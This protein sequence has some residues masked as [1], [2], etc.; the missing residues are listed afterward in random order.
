MSLQNTY[1]DWV[2][3]ELLPALPQCIAQRN[4]GYWMSAMEV[5]MWKRCTRRSIGNEKC[6]HH[7]Y[8][9]QLSCITDQCSPDLI[10]R[11]LPYCSRSP[12]AK[13][14]FYHW[15]VQVTGRTWFIDVGDAADV[16]K[17]TPASLVDGYASIGVVSQAPSDLT[18][19]E[20]AH[21]RV[22]F[23]SAIAS[24]SFTGMPQHRE[25]IAKDWESDEV[26]YMKFLG[27]ESAAYTLTQHSVAYG[28]YFD[29]ACFCKTF[30]LNLR[31]PYRRIDM[32]QQR[33]W[34]NATCGPKSLFS[35]WTNNLMTIGSAYIAKGDW[36]WPSCVDDIP[37]T[38]LNLT[39]SCAEKACKIDSA[40]YCQK[41][42]AIDRSC[43]CNQISYDSCGGSCHLFETRIDYVKWMHR[44]CGDVEGWHG[45]PEDW[46]KLAHPTSQDIIPR[47]WTIT[48]YEHT[49]EDGIQGSC[50]SSESMLVGLILLNVA[51]LLAAF[52]A[53][54]LD[55][56]RIL[57]KVLW[58]P[59][60]WSFIVYGSS[61][62]AVQL[63]GYWLVA[64]I[65]QSTPHFP[66]VAVH[67]LILFFC[68][69][70]RPAWLKAAFFSLQKSDV[71]TISLAASALWSELILQIPTTYYMFTTVSYGW[72][73]SFYWNSMEIAKQVPYAREFYAGAALWLL[74]SFLGFV[75]IVL[76][77]VIALIVL[78][79]RAVW[80]PLITHKHVQLPN[81]DLNKSPSALN[82]FR[83][84]FN[85]RVTPLNKWYLEQEDTLIHRWSRQFRR[86]DLAS[87]DGAQPSHETIC[88]VECDTPW[89]QRLIVRASII[90]CVS[91]LAMWIAQWLFWVGFIGLSRETYVCN[92]VELM[93]ETDITRLCIPRF[94]LAI[95]I[96]V[97]AS[98]VEN[99]LGGLDGARGGEIEYV[100]LA[101]L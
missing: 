19:A 17:L 70:P 64:Y 35:N 10:G 61:S 39:N 101:S 79:V 95:I 38:V 32:T 91:L 37:K 96:W 36:A 47:Q 44:L 31:E 5:C 6:L 62:A 42:N 49:D 57:R 74:I 45:L 82:A 28:H 80:R 34:M 83:V 72:E 3:P 48:Q 22:S 43:F 68:S 89:Y 23:N 69:L 9:T 90:C 12:L 15:I 25:N 29:K 50:A 67:Q 1:G 76:M 66:H 33:L 71:M 53:W 30:K 2:D 75:L 60:S 81:R 88:P 98:L 84:G 99:V 56:Q 77:V 94:W 26:K 18:K 4:Q 7:E 55:I 78:I 14:Q 59:S 13:A 97:A 58:R 41:T 93:G 54:R 21:S 20:S 65:I 11:Y 52:F 51:S 100:P 8:I 24:C 86:S 85:E 92:D 40:G 27:S 16:Q 63:L 73:H 87:L 46:Q